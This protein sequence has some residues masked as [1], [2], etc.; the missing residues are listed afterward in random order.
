MGIRR[1]RHFS[2][3]GDGGG[4]GADRIV[5]DCVAEVGDLGLEEVALTGVGAEVVLF[6]ALEDDGKV[7]RVF[8][9][10]VAEDADV[11]DKESDKREVTEHLLHVPL[12]RRWGV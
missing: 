11:V 4:V 1:R 7:L 6:K 3:G 9:F 10:R 12:H 2:D 5:G 8:V